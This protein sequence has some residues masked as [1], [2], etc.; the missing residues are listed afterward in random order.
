M[1]WQQSAE[2]FRV[3]R[4]D[5]DKVYATFALKRVVKARESLRIACTKWLT[6]KAQLKIQILLYSMSIGDLSRTV[7]G[8]LLH[9]HGITETVNEK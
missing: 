9:G 6:L 7:G 8:A 4:Y 1:R 5:T 3:K 2:P